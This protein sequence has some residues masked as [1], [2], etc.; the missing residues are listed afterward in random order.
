L[1]RLLLV[2]PPLLQ[3]SSHAAGGVPQMLWSLASLLVERGSKVDVAISVGTT[4][5]LPEGELTDE[6]RAMMQAAEQVQARRVIAA[7]AGGSYDMVL[8]Q[9]GHLFQHG[10]QMECLMLATLFRP[11]IHY[12]DIA[13]RD[14]APNVFFTCTS[15]RMRREFSNVPH[16]MAPVHNGIDMQRYPAA[17]RRANYVMWMGSVAPETAPH[18]VVQ[19]ARAAGQTILLAADT[20]LFERHRAYYEE[21]VRPLV[22]HDKVRWVQ[23]ESFDQ[24]TKMLREARA[25]LLA[26]QNDMV[27]PHAALEALACGTPVISFDAGDMSEIVVEGTGYLVNSV[28]GMTRAL[29]GLRDLR[30][31]ECR[32]QIE[33]N[34]SLRSMA[35]GYESLLHDLDEQRRWN[36]RRK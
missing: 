24:K 22:D 36:R 17:G 14:P 30:S 12:P 19:A 5:P 11:R 20:E 31:L 23:L 34:F 1:R 25:I 6:N 9:S 3:V 33:E 13:F 16:M 28:E 15:E 2:P 26:P 29:V 27:S 10:A 18:L 21:Q 32:R 7:C 8:D 35:D 4:F